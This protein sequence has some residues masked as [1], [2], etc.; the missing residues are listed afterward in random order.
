MCL[1]R[2]NSVETISNIPMFIACRGVELLLA[3]MGY[4]G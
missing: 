3:I 4:L 2:L 1:D